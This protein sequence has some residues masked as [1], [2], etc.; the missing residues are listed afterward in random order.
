MGRLQNFL[1]DNLNSCS[2]HNSGF[3]VL[4]AVEGSKI[5]EAERQVAEQDFQWF[6]GTESFL[7]SA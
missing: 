2:K 3:L 4:T 6:W 5:S 1:P 7:D